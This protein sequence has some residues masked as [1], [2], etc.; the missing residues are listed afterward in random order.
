M[1]W[2]GSEINEVCRELATDPEAGLSSVEAEKRLGIY[3][4][5]ISSE[6]KQSSFREL[7]IAR[8]SDAPTVLLLIATAISALTALIMHEGSALIPFITALILVIRALLSAAYELKT[9]RALGSSRVLSVAEARVIRDKCL[10]RLPS[11]ELVPGDII[12]LEAGDY[13]PADARLLSASQLHCGEQPL[14]GEAVPAEKGFCETPLDDITPISERKNMVFKGCSV[15][16]GTAKAVI[17]ATG[18]DTELKKGLRFSSEEDSVASPVMKRLGRFEGAIAV[19]TVAVCSIA[20]I[21]GLIW[22]IA[23]REGFSLKL[24]TLLSSVLALAAAVCS[25]AFKSAARA[26]VAYGIRQSASSGAILKRIRS[27]ESL[28]N[29]SVICCDKTGVLTEGANEV[30][31]L[32]DG[33]KLTRLSTDEPTHGAINLLTFAA[34]CGNGSGRLE[35]GRPVREGNPVD[36]GIALAALR[37]LRHSRE[38]LDNACPC[39]AC[40]PFESDEG[41]MITVN[42]IDGKLYAVIKGAPERVLSLCDGFDFDATQDAADRMSA[43]ALKVIAVA[44]K[45]LSELPMELKKPSAFKG[46]TL[47][48]LIG[49]SDPIRDDTLSALKKCRATG[50]RTVMVTGDSLET[51]SAVAERLGFFENGFIA[52]DGRTV[53]AMTDEELFEQAERI[54][55]FARISS[56]NKLRI[57]RALRATG[58]SVAV[59]GDT[60]GDEQALREADVGFALGASGTDVARGAADTVL[61]DNSFSSL[62]SALEIGHTVYKNMRRSLQYLLACGVGEAFILLF[63]LAIFGASPLAAAPLLLLSLLINF[64]PLRAIQAEPTAIGKRDEKVSMRLFGMGGFLLNGLWQGAVIGTFG[65]L[66]Y[67]LGKSLYPDSSSA[68]STLCFAVML[69]SELFELFAVRSLS[70]SFFSGQ[71]SKNIYVFIYTAAAAAIAALIILT[72]LSGL[73]GMSSLSAEGWLTVL[74]FSVVFLVITELVKTLISLLRQRA[75]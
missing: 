63:G 5:N 53:S 3:G 16:S 28:G 39:L 61:T 69:F 55:V 54:S 31:C 68:A 45:R 40:L 10:R 46:A 8:F 43:E 41:L 50:I 49:L 72:P 64:L 48:G 38:E 32:F 37:L 73:F 30:S 19:G 9:V 21:I 7:L 47:C 58:A 25:G 70:T 12:L 42:M 36:S 29:V 13:I 71:L 66:A 18:N 17:T 75:R 35:A 26:S 57:V 4:R 56:E 51:A 2:H 74:L 23:D 27:A 62:V 67:A 44:Y 52:V 34:I 59:T 24:L 11:D 1:I 14:T 6:I 22:I 33:R 15:V 65:L 60:V 20:F